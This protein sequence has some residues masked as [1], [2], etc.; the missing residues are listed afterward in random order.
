MVEIARTLNP[1]IGIL[2]RTHS[3]DEAAM[4]RAENVG[5]VFMGEHELALAMA[6][7]VVS[8]TTRADQPAL[9]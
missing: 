1:R 4:W 7:S 2:L 6:R 3:D 5:E 8:K 9:S